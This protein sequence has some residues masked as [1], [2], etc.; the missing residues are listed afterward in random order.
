VA[1]D[2]RGDPHPIA[3]Q[4]TY[5]SEP[6]DQFQAKDGTVSHVA[7]ADAVPVRASLADLVGEPRPDDPEW[8]AQYRA[9]LS[10]LKALGDVLPDPAFP[11][12]RGDLG[13]LIWDRDQ[14]RPRLWLCDHATGELLTDGQGAR[15]PASSVRATTLSRRTAYGPAERRGFLVCSRHVWSRP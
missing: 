10:R 3:R 5:R 1:S 2:A 8:R 13:R 14:R 9:N 12:R 15:M 4:L 7:D 6:R 11:W